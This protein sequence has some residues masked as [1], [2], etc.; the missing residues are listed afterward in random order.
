MPRHSA[1]TSFL[2]RLRD[3]FGFLRSSPQPINAPPSIQIQPR[4]LNFSSFPVKSAR[5]PVDIAPYCEEDL[6][7]QRYA[8]T[9]E[10]D[11]EAGAALLRMNSNTGQL[12]SARSSHSGGTR[13]S[14]TK[15]SG[16]KVY[17]G[18]G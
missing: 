13:V 17:S 14:R 2:P 18:C 3:F 6:I 8:I 4:R 11:A 9:P 5:C 16:E 7:L 15:C 1:D 10:S 12:N